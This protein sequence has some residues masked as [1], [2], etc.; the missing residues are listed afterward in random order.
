MKI[1]KIAILLISFCINLVSFL[2]GF[3]SSDVKVRLL[4]YEHPDMVT[5]TVSSGA[6]RITDSLDHVFVLHESESVIA[7][8]FGKKIYMKPRSGE[9]FT[10]DTV[11]LRGN[12]DNSSFSLRYGAGNPTAIHYSGDLKCF[13]D[14]MK[15]ILV[16]TCNIEKY[17]EGVVMAEGGGGKNEEYFK[18]QAVIARTYTYKYITKH[19]P[20]GFNLCDDTHCQAY[21]GIINDSLIIKAVRDT[22][23][24]VI[25]TSDSV[26]IISAFHSNCGGETSPSEFAWVTPQPYLKRVEDP[27]CRDSRNAQWKRRFTLNEWGNMLKINGFAGSMDNPGIF[28]FDQSSRMEDY[29][30][31]NYSI[32]LRNI[33]TRLNLKSTFFSVRVDGD[34]VYL[35]GKGYG[36]GVGL[37]QEGAINMAALGK[38]YREI[39]NFYY[40]DV[41]MINIEFVKK[42]RDDN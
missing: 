16:N 37:C 17:L 14:M 13:A 38:S 42:V 32:P 12:T 36:H 1:R 34:S 6:Y 23:G 11:F 39:I 3:A 35:A 22:K 41:R 5:I 19:N 27:Y 30:A 2:S 10:C 8:K 26:L 4:T 33:R 24:Q 28:N 31:G 18:A 15:L 25:T 9:G 40:A 21:D 20:D 29:K 7:S